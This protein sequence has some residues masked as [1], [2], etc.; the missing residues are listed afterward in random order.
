M[1]DFGCTLTSAH[2]DARSLNL[3]LF[4]VGVSLPDEAKA[5]VH[6]T[7]RHHN[8]PTCALTWTLEHKTYSV[9]LMKKGHA[10]VHGALSLLQCRLVLQEIAVSLLQNPKNFRHPDKVKDM[11]PEALFSEIHAVN[12]TYVVKFPDCPVYSARKYQRL[13]FPFLKCKKKSIP[14]KKTLVLHNWDQRTKWMKTGSMVFCFGDLGRRGVVVGIEKPENVVAFAGRVH[15]ALMKGNRE[16]VNDA[17][18]LLLL[19]ALLDQ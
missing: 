15:T 18:T 9:Y 6:N 14:Q 8:T 4:N 16:H 12:W 7:S 1:T 3:N 11:T 19:K 17:G 13:L 2:Y 10:L 5:R